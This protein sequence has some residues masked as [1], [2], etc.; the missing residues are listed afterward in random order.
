MNANQINYLRHVTREITRLE[1][2]KEYISEK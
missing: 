2:A 1:E